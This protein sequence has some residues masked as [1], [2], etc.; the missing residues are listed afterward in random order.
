MKKLSFLLSIILITISFANAQDY[1]IS[2]AAEGDATNVETVE[3]QNLTQETNLTLN[4][5]DI[6]HL[7]SEIS[8]TNELIVQNEKINIFPNPMQHISTINI[9]AENQGLYSIEIFNIEGKKVISKTLNLEKGCHNFKIS[10]LQ[11][12][13]YLV[14]MCSEKFI[15]STKLIVTGNSSSFPN[16][17][18][19]GI[20]GNINTKYSKETVQMQYNEGDLLLFKGISEDYSSILTTIPTDDA[21]LTFMFYACTDI[22]GNHYTTVNIGEQV[23]MAEDLRVTTFPNGDAIPNITD[24][25]EWGDLD[26]NDTEIAYCFY[27]NDNTTD[28][29]A[30]YTYAAAIAN[31]WN[32]D[33]SE[34][35]GVCPDGWH[36][37]TKDEWVEL[38]DFLGGTTLAGGKMKET[39][40]T[41]WNEEGE[42]T[43][44]SSGFTALPGGRRSHYG[45]AFDRN[46]DYGYWWTATEHN[47]SEAWR[48]MIDYYNVDVYKYYEEKSRGFSVRCVKNQ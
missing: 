12:G 38:T 23:W 48:C 16:L 17:E 13:I 10:G 46:G 18:Y 24:D 43:T 44:N 7:V 11:S 36:L 34:G 2:F 15:K 4:G 33:I 8:S 14:N 28:Y 37:P 31:D 20:S 3:V 21:T 26:D 9:L 5:S 41:H 35:Q 45:G 29:G 19:S 42:N 47:G 39:G 40:T 6:L 27:N 1:Q 32:F 22:D 25:T 30:L